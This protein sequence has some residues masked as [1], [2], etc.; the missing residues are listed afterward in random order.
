MMIPDDLRAA[1]RHLRAVRAARPREGVGGNQRRW[2]E[3][4][5]A[6]LE[7]VADSAVFVSDREQASAEAAEYRRRATG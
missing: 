4:M 7:S 3:D 5:A 6:A 1:L 2:Y